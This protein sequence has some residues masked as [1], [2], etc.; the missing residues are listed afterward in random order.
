[1][2]M[3]TNVDLQIYTNTKIDQLIPHI[4]MGL[5]H[6]FLDFFRFIFQGQLISISCINP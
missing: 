2:H 4:Q 5:F 6:I 3:A 1:M